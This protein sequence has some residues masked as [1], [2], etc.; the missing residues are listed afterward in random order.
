MQSGKITRYR[1]HL[2]DIKSCQKVVQTHLQICGITCEAWRSDCRCS[3]VSCRVAFARIVPVPRMDREELHDRFARVRQA[4][5]KDSALAVSSIS[6]RIRRCG[7]SLY[8]ILVVLWLRVRQRFVFGASDFDHSSFQGS[9]IR[10]ISFYL[11]EPTNHRFLFPFRKGNDT[12]RDFCS[13]YLFPRRVIVSVYK[14][15]LS[16]QLRLVRRLLIAQLLVAVRD[17]SI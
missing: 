8:T 13:T 7:L 2:R 9:S 1:Y 11:Y 6:I 16:K 17:P 15:S 12:N 3:V 10:T 14:R 4:W 5:P